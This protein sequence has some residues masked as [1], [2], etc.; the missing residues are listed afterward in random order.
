MNSLNSVD[1]I[2]EDVEESSSSD[3]EEFVVSRGRVFT[4]TEAR[5]RA[6][7]IGK[8]YFSFEVG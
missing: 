7:S 4:G 6:A 1:V 3:E 8:A 5:I 2:V